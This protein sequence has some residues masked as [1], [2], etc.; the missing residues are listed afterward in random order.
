M[1]YRVVYVIYSKE[2]CD[3]T[4][5]HRDLAHDIFQARYNTIIACL[6]YIIPIS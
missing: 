4:R 1:S 3:A 5:L 6:K 2:S